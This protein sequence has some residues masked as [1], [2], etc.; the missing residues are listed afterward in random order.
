M[1]FKDAIEIVFGLSLLLV[2]LI[3]VCVLGIVLWIVKWTVPVAVV[4]VGLRLF[5][6]I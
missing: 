1:N 4:L 6:V 3:V 5:G 2:A